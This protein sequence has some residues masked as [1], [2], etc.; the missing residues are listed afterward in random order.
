MMLDLITATLAA[1]S[2]ALRVLEEAASCAV[3]RE[4]DRATRKAW[5]SVHS[6]LCAAVLAAD[7]SHRC[8]MCGD[9]D[10]LIRCQW[11]SAETCHDPQ[12]QRTIHGGAMECPHTPYEATEAVRQ[13]RWFAILSAYPEAGNT[14]STT[15]RRLRDLRKE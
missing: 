13:A 14:P 12:C 3:E 7:L 2:G 9:L 1:F 11:C 6:S 4:T 8:P 15:S 5:E 10:D